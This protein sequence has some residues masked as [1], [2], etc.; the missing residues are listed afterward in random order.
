MWETLWTNESPFQKQEMPP[1]DMRRKK[2]GKFD[3]RTHWLTAEE[4]TCTAGQSYLQ[5]RL[6]EV[7]G[8]HAAIHQRTADPLASGH[9][10]DPVLNQWFVDR[11]RQ[12]AALLPVDYWYAQSSATHRRVSGV[13]RTPL[14]TRRCVADAVGSLNDGFSSLLFISPLE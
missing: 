8:A 3:L 7:V 6:T 9:C 5:T 13:L 1:Q 11:Y 2:A 12:L 14:V 4:E 10:L